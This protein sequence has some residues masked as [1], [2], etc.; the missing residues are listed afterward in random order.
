[1]TGTLCTLVGRRVA[2]N[3]EPSNLG[4]LTLLALSAARPAQA[5]APRKVSLTLQTNVVAAIPSRKDMR[6]AS[7]DLAWHP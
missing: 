2:L 1:M 7:T 4:T 6:G 5:V 3:S